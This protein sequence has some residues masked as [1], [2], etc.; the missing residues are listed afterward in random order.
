MKKGLFWSVCLVFIITIC[1]C[2]AEAWNP[3]GTWVNLDQE[4]GGTHRLEISFP[5]VHGYGQCT[6]NPCD[7]GNAI[8]TSNLGATND[9]GNTAKDQYMAAWIFV[10]K[11]TFAY[12]A[13]HPENPSYIILTTYDL[14]DLSGGS[15]SENRVTIEYLK[16]AF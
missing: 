15:A 2:D 9:S 14:Y 1:V 11:W 16:K 5:T 8:Y 10:F 3:N 12:I 13:P 4:G 6:P 7:W